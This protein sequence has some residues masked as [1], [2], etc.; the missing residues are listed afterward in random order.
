M[1]KVHKAIIEIYS[2]VLKHED[3][4]EQWVE[5]EDINVWT[6]GDGGFWSTLGQEGAS[7]VNGRELKLNFT[8]NERI[9]IGIVNPSAI[10]GHHR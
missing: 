1:F 10:F 7:L 4:I 9:G 5:D 6:L 2:G 8:I 3:D